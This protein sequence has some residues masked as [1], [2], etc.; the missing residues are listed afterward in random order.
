MVEKNFRIHKFTA[1]SQFLAAVG[2]YKSQCMV[3]LTLGSLDRHFLQE[4]S[5]GM[6]TW[7]V[8]VSLA[9][10]GITAITIGYSPS[11]LVICFILS[12]VALVFSF[13]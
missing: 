1:E 11:A 4:R 13:V 10:R 8:V 7:G 5:L 9:V 6:L 3:I 12:P 2:T